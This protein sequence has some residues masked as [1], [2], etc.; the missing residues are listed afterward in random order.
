VEAVPDVDLYTLGLAVM[1][2]LAVGLMLIGPQ[3]ITWLTE[4]FGLDQLFVAL[5]TWLRIPVAILLMMLAVAM[6]YYFAPNCGAEVPGHHSRRSTRGALLGGDFA[7][8]LLLREQ[9]SATTVRRMA[10]LAPSSC[11]SCTSSY[12]PRCCS[13]GAEVNAVNRAPRPEGKG[14]GRQ[15]LTRL[16]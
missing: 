2:V 8:V 12:L 16:S 5:W 7:G 6:I 15:E 1:L 14:L 3:V 9:F 4:Q 10:A 13:L 11:C